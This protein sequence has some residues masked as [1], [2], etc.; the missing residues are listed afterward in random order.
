MF[1]NKAQSCETGQSSYCLSLSIREMSVLTDP[2]LYFSNFFPENLKLAKSKTQQ[3]MFYVP[4][5]SASDWQASES[6]L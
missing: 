5:I 3:S 6:F 1:Y 2:Y 4:M